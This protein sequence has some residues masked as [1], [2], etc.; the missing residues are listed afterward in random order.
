MSQWLWI[1]T[2]IVV[3]LV[4]YRF[5]SFLTGALVATS[6]QKELG[7]LRKRITIAAQYRKDIQILSLLSK[8]HA[9]ASTWFNR[10]QRKELEREM[11]YALAYYFANTQEKGYW[12]SSRL[13]FW[14]YQRWVRGITLPAYIFLC[15]FVLIP[16][17]VRFTTGYSDIEQIAPEHETYVLTM[18]IAAMIACFAG[19]S[20]YGTDVFLFL[21]KLRRIRHRWIERDCPKRYH[22][23]LLGGYFHYTNRNLNMSSGQKIETT[24]RT[25]IR[26]IKLEIEADADANIYQRINCILDEIHLSTR[27]VDISQ[28]TECEIELISIKSLDGEEIA[29]AEYMSGNRS[30]DKYEIVL[31]RYW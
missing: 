31:K 25:P 1:T 4:G 5:Y 26:P 7:S 19:A 2:C 28:A 14:S 21:R 13:P 24:S 30:L 17:F 18:G 12:F 29:V 11:H 9:G 15:K 22:A 6:L 10:S 27:D 23:M 3:T 16:L 20:L 8:I